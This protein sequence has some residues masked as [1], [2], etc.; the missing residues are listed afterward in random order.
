M[1]WV[2]PPKLTTLGDRWMRLLIQHGA[3]VNLR[4]SMG[5]SAADVIFNRPG[6]D[7]PFAER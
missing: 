3:D 6:Q 5:Y 4:D 1:S 7:S 2:M